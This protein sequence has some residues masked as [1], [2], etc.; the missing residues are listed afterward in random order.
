MSGKITKLLAKL[1]PKQLAVIKAAVAQILKG[2][3]TGLDIK[4]I[5]GQKDIFRVRLGRYRI[6]FKVVDK[7]PRILSISK[8]DEQTYRDF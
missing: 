5:K 4:M 7:E 8:R 2:D 1:P 3:Y 6:I